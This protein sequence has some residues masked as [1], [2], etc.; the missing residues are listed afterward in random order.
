METEK[1]DTKKSII[2][3]PHDVF[4]GILPDALRA[5]LKLRTL[6]LDTTSYTDEKLEQYFSDV[7]YNCSY[8]SGRSMVKLALLFEH[9]SFI[10]QFPHAQLLR[11]I[12]NIW[13]NH[14]KQKKSRPIILPIIFFHGRRNWEQLPLHAY[15]SGDTELYSRFIP[16]FEYVL[17]NLREYNQ[18]T[19]TN[20]FSRN[21]GVKLWLLIQKHIYTPKIVL[22]IL[23]NLADSDIL[24]LTTEEGLR[25]L[26][27]MCRYLFKATSLSAETIIKAV[28]PLPQ[29]GKEAIMT[30][31]EKLMEQGE[32]KKARQTA[33][34]MLEEG[35][36]IDLIV[37]VTGLSREEVEGLR[38]G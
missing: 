5:N 28:T 22:E 20:M 24:F 21:P 18:D 9:K 30:T 36:D 23:E 16:D 7:V 12:N 33:Q 25:V 32:L 27:T 2:S 1:D 37:R 11:Y 35:L 26:E 4:G 13:D 31:A 3:N 34:R 29:N 15:L 17:I 19:I 14:T 6:K 8:M 10:P 38:K